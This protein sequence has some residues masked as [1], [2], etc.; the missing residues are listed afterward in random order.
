MTYRPRL[1]RAARHLALPQVGEFGQAR[2]AR[3]KILLVGLGGLGCAAAS[4][5]GSSGVGYLILNDFDTVD[6]TNLARQPLYVP[7]D[8]GKLKVDCAA[9]RLRQQNPDI[10]VSTIP[11]R[12]D[13][14][15]LHNAVS[16]VD[17]VIDGCDNFATRFALND[18]CVRASRY[19]VSGSAVRL[20]GQ[21]A[22]FGADYSRSPCYRCLYAE[23]DESL[24]NCAGNGVLAP[25][26]AVIGSLMAVEALKL[27]AGIKPVTGK[28]TLYDA[29]SGDWRSVGFSRRDGCEGCGGV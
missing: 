2:I 14:D 22:V 1:Q 24:D 27:A 4:Y 17:I 12:M 20:E 13:G 3:A 29:R 7:A 28:L 21:I 26:P 9:E 16:S 23:A 25:V 6:E 15:V 19:L 8:V 11:N 18:A 5:L 10:R